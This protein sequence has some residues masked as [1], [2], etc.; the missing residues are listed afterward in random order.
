MNKNYQISILIILILLTFLTNLF[1]EDSIKRGTDIQFERIS[2]EQ[3]LSQ[4]VIFCILQDNQGFMWFGTQD[5]L[6][7][8]DGYTFKVYNHIPENPNSLS[9]NSIYSIYEDNEGFLWIAT[10][11]GGLDKFNKETEEFVHYNANPD[12]PNSLSNDNISAIYEDKQGTLWIVASKEINRFDRENDNFIIYPKAPIDTTSSHAYKCKIEYESVLT[13]EKDT[14][15]KEKD[16]KLER[17][18]ETPQGYYKFDRESNKFSFYQSGKDSTR[19]WSRQRVI[20]A[21]YEDKAGILWIGTGKGL[22]KY[23][24]EKDESTYYINDPANPNSLSNNT[25]LSIY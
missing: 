23:D 22:S 16:Y 4:S 9:H 5:G 14:I 6:N 25:F 19:S 18:I 17:K 1:A 7:K 10:A 3:G 15:W 2:V 8:Y 20:Q 24:K 21:F 11:G 12:D 13:Y